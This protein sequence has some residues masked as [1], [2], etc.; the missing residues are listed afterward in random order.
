MYSKKGEEYKVHTYRYEIDYSWRQPNGRVMDR[1]VNVKW[2]GKQTVQ[3]DRE[4]YMQCITLLCT[5]RGHPQQDKNY[6]TPKVQPMAMAALGV[7]TAQNLNLI[8]LQVMNSPQIKQTILQKPDYFK[9]PSDVFSHLNFQNY[10][11]GAGYTSSDPDKSTHI[12]KLRSL[13]GR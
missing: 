10:I 1:K 12:E 2:D 3:L 7:Q 6:W 5:I 11:T 9:D 4:N 8:R 13:A